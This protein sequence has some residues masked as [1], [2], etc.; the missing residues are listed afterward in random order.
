[1]RRCGKSVLLEQYMNELKNTGVSEEQI[2][3][4]N[5][6]K[7]ESEAYLDRKQL[8]E[9]LRNSIKPDRI[10][11]IFLDEIQNVEGWELT[12]SALNAKGNCDVYITGSNSN[13][14][15]S[16]LATHTSGRHVE[17]KV[18]PLSFAEFMQLNKLSDRLCIRSIPGMGRL[19]W[20]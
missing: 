1:M 11:Y 17:I 2:I 6:E 14:L 12:L 20:T 18:F 15:S 7:F 10:T 4:I 9:H 3:H 19:S 13:I 16:Q 5:F 8:N